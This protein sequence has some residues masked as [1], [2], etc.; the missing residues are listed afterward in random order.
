[1]TLEGGVTGTEGALLGRHGVD[2]L[3][4]TTD[5]GVI[6]DLLGIVRMVRAEGVDRRFHPIDGFMEHH[7]PRP[8]IEA[9]A[10]DVLAKALA[11]VARIDHH[12]LAPLGQAGEQPLQA[13]FLLGIAGRAD[14]PQG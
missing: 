14:L 5:Q 7:Q 4:I 11:V 1:M 2:H 8:G 6:T 13:G 12:P 3:A 10:A 9:V